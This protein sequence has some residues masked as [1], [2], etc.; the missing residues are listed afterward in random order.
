MPR[1]IPPTPTEVPFKVASSNY[2]QF[3]IIPPAKLPSKITFQNDFQFPMI[4]GYTMFATKYS[5]QH[6]SYSDP[7][8]LNE[9]KNTAVKP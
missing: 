1:V 9:V 7:L 2:L 5:C 4:P 6:D 3:P 8:C